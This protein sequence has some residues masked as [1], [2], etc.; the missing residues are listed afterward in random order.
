[1]DEKESRRLETLADDILKK[2]A[3]RR[4]FVAPTGRGFT[5][6]ERAIGVTSESGLRRTYQHEAVGFTEEE[7][8]H[9]ATETET[10]AIRRRR[11]AADLDQ[12]PVETAATEETNVE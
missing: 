12:A 10:D 9:L 4:G 5:K 6:Y 1:M 11:E 2:D 7:L 8:D 3:R